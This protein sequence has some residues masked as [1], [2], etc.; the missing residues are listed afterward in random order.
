MTK[1]KHNNIENIYN[2]YWGQSLVCWLKNGIGVIT[3]LNPTPKFCHFQQYATYGFVHGIGNI[4]D[5]PAIF[6]FCTVFG[7]ISDMHMSFHGNTVSSYFPK[8]QAL[9]ICV[10]KCD[11]NASVLF[12]LPG[13]KVV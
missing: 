4:L 11:K 5:I 3:S 13:E 12:I 6:V 1:M 10:K 2:Y 7:A 9:K 8:D